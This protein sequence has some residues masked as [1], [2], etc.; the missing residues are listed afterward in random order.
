MK[1]L[2]SNEAIV[3]MNSSAKTSRGFYFFYLLFY[4]LL[5]SSERTQEKNPEMTKIISV[6]KFEPENA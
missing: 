6:T 1:N 3:S 2:Q 4:Y 5:D